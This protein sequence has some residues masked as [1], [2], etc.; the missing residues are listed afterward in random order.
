MKNQL[1]KT[2][3]DHTRNYISLDYEGL[4]SLT[5][6][7]R[8]VIGNR[9]IDERHIKLFTTYSEQQ[10]RN[11]PAITVNERTGRLIDGQH[12]V[13]AIIKMIEQGKLPKD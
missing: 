13:R 5:D 10:L 2:A 8:K 9:M 4:K 3:Y 6:D 11:M 1:F 7:S 12:R